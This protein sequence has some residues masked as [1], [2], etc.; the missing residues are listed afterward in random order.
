MSSAA[1]SRDV[2]VMARHKYQHVSINLN[3]VT[4]EINRQ[5]LDNYSYHSLYLLPTLTDKQH[6]TTY[7]ILELVLNL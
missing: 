4:I 1:A 7:T 6:G 2:T 5:F 3:L